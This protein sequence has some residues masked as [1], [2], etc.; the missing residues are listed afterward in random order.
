MGRRGCQDDDDTDNLRLALVRAVN[1]GGLGVYR[2]GSR[3]LVIAVLIVLA[4]PFVVRAQPVG[5][6]AFLCPGNCSNLPH[7][8]GTWDRGFL[9]GLAQTGYEL[10][11][12]ASVDVTGVGV[13]N[14]RLPNAA[15]RLVTR[16]VDVIVAVGNEATRAASQVTKSTPI[17][18]L[19][20]ADAVE[21]GLVASLGRPGANVT[22]LTMPLGQLT[23]KHIEILKEINPRLERVAVLWTPTIRRDEERFQRLERAARSL[24]V[25]LSSLDM[26]TFRDLETAFDSTRHGRP[27]GLLLLDPVLGAGA[28]SSEIALFAL[29][30]KVVTVASSRFFVEAGG[31]LGY[32]PHLADM[33]ERAAIYA[34]KL[35]KG[36][37]PGE[38]PVEEPTRF[39][40]IV[41]K[42]TAKALALTI[43]PS[44][45]LRA[46][47]VIE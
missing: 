1:C 24:G 5:K 4:A 23:A 39:E 3:S 44:I 20:V 14:D 29:Q 21:D 35:L 17:V 36:A 8:V 7:P 6:V 10:G 9:A 46:D 11:R 43:P 26:V 45:L 32:G 15:R 2:V 34:G 33:Y 40:L 19:N 38:L 30:R 12:N 28:V 18:M 41:N 25:R 22:G 31:L 47:H 27:Q 42:A 13:G 16:K 37:R